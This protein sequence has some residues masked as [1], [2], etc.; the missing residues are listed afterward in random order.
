MIMKLA[1]QTPEILPAM[2]GKSLTND[3][4]LPSTAIVY[5]LVSY[6]LTNK[7][8]PSS[9]ESIVDKKLFTEGS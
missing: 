7:H 5:G 4:V 1:S 3:Q 2:M 8:Y 6:Y 9:L